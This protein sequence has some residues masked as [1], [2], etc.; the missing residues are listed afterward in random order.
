MPYLF[1]SNIC[2]CP[3]CLDR[4]YVNALLIWIQIWKCST[5]LDPNMIMPYLFGSKYVN[6][7]LIWIVYMSMSYLF[8]S[9]ICKRSTFWFL[10]I[11]SLLNWI[12]YVYALLIRI[13]ICE[14]FSN[15]DPNML[16]TYLFGSNI[17]KCST[18]LDPN[19]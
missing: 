5:Y 8:G 13:Q 6:A 10:N 14:C 1:G 18:Y 16:M 2:K 15:L 12:Q 7:Q 19:M 11:N 3:T 17:C 4:L 9:Y